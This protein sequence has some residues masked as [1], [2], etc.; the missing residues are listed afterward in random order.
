MDDP[1]SWRSTGL[2]FAS[3]TAAAQ[4]A[5]QPLDRALEGHLARDMQG[6]GASDYG[7]DSGSSS[8][9]DD[10]GDSDGTDS[11]SGSDSKDGS[12]EDAAPSSSGLAASEPVVIDAAGRQQRWHDLS[13]QQRFPVQTRHEVTPP[14]AAGS[15]SRGAIKHNQR[16]QPSSRELLVESISTSLLLSNR[17]G[18]QPEFQSEALSAAVA[19]ATTAAAVL[20]KLQVAQYAGVCVCVPAASLRAG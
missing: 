6:A 16:G 14:P 5:G 9:S 18:C 12:D 17:Q 3:S 1:D 19:A 13:P 8:S 20:A 15:S 11:S 10:D 7:S 2:G 4:F